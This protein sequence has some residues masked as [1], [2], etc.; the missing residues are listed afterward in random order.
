MDHST[1]DEALSFES[2]DPI[3]N[4]PWKTYVSTYKDSAIAAAV[5][6][7]QLFIPT[8]IAFIAIGLIQDEHSAVCGLSLM[9]SSYWAILLGSDSVASR[10]VTRGARLMAWLQ[11]I[12]LII[13]AVAAIVT[14]LGLY[15]EV[16]VGNKLVAVPFHYAADNSP[17]GRATMPRSD[18]KSLRICYDTEEG[19]PNAPDNVKELDSVEYVSIWPGSVNIFTSGETAPTVASIF[20]I[21]WRNYYENNS[22]YLG[23]N[24]N[25]TFAH[26]KY[27][28]L[29]KFV[30]EEDVNAVEGLLVDSK[31]GRLGFRNHTILVDAGLGSIITGPGSLPKTFRLTRAY[32]PVHGAAWHQNMMLMQYLNIS[33]N[34]SD[35][36]APFSFLKSHKGKV[37]ELKTPSGIYL[38]HNTLQSTRA[39]GNFVDLPDYYNTSSNSTLPPVRM[40]E[41]RANPLN[42][43]E[44]DFRIM[45]KTSFFNRIFYCGVAGMEKHLANMSFVGVQC[46]LV[47]GVSQ[48][49]NNGTKQNGFSLSGKWSVPMYSCATA[50]KASIKAVSFKYNGTDG[51]NSLQVDSIKEKVYA[52]NDEL[53][54]WGVE[55]LSNFTIKQA[56]PL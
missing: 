5:F 30:L 34:G 18:L 7:V 11:P 36:S 19:C 53:P 25:K 43:T 6:I 52:S 55:R 8:A 42:L 39:Y 33:T 3:S 22:P 15:D 1:V 45:G 29:S 16:S 20:D 50:T 47:F 48:R 10:G 31:V 32:T 37:F 41:T 44:R 56:R 49:I 54:V 28:Q 21:E 2:A 26:G 13:V 40:N 9:H 38:A 24:G 51:L 12:S 4:S 27:L 23:L 14:P 46:G 35:G 17:F